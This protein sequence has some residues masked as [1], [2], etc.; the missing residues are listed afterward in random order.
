MLFDAEK[1]REHAF[2]NIVRNGDECQGRSHGIQFV[3]FIL[4][5]QRDNAHS[6]LTSYALYFTQFTAA[7]QPAFVVKRI[8][9]VS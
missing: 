8:L 2:Y 1:D 9:D 3:I 7:K 6:C 4:N 5:L